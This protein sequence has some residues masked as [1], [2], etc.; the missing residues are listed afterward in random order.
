MKTLNLPSS[1]VRIHGNLL[2]TN[3]ILE[4]PSRK[5]WKVG[6]DGSFESLSVSFGEGFQSFVADH[7]LQ[8]GDQLCFILP[9]RS[10]LQ[11]QVQKSQPK[12]KLY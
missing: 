12:P 3:V 2:S 4:G 10:H 11:V 7:V 6:V 9:A 5:H 8:L 1:V